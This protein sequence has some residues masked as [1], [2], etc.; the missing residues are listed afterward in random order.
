V[1][2]PTRV[3]QSR[4]LL[5]GKGRDM[6]S[7]ILGRRATTA[8]DFAEAFTAERIDLLAEVPGPAALLAL[9]RNRAGPR[10]GLYVLDDG[11]GRFRVYHQERGEVIDPRQGLT[12][13]QARDVAIE[14]V[15]L[16]SGIPFRPEG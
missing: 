11:D 2:I 7:R 10:D 13:D 3:E 8:A 12:F 4:A 14:R 16:L 5:A 9:G 15:L 6:A 1:T